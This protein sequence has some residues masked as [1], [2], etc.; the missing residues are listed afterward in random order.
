MSYPSPTGID[1]VLVAQEYNPFRDQEP[2]TVI[3]VYVTN[4]IRNTNN[5]NDDCSCHILELCTLA[6][7][8]HYLCPFPCCLLHLW[9]H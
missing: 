1:K 8:F 9:F 4:N 7:C 2:R 6:F 3:N 5:P